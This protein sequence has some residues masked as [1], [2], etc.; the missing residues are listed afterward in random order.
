MKESDLSSEES[1]DESSDSSG[2]VRKML[3][4]AP[5]AGGCARS[6]VTE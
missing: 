2:A 6:V 3:M 4:T 1:D 5:R